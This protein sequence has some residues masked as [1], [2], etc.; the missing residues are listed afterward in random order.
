M[1]KKCMFCGVYKELESVPDN[2]E[3]YVCYRCYLA[4][5]SAL[6]GVYV[7]CEEDEEID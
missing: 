6:N 5:L 4:F 1:I 7:P 3:G 2:G